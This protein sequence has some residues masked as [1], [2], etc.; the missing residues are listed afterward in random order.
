M[1]SGKPWHGPRNAFLA[2]LA[3]VAVLGTLF[4]VFVIQDLG[5]PMLGRGDLA[6]WTFQGYYL[7]H[8]LTLT[9][10]PHLDL[11]ND[12]LF[13]PYGGNNVFQPWVLEM[14]LFTTIAD[15]ALGSG[16][17]VQLYYL[18]T[19]LVTAL[20]AYVLLAGEHGASRASLAAIAVSF[21]NFYAI[22]KYPEHAGLACCHWM[23]L[24]LLADAILVRRMVMGRPWSARLLALRALL[25][26]LL[27]GQDLGYVAGIALTSSCLCGLYCAILVLARSRFR[28]TRIAVVVKQSLAS[29]GSSAR[30]HRSQVL[31]VAF[32]A[33]VV[34]LL[35]TPL[36]LEISEAARGFDFAH[37]GVGGWWANPARL[38]IPYLPG[39]N[40]GTAI[41]VFNDQMESGHDQSPGL[42]FVLWGLVGLVWGMRSWRAWLPFAVLLGLLV[43]FHPGRL[44]FL[45][46][47]PWFE[48]ARVSGRFTLAY[49]A[50]LSILGLCIP[51]VGWRG[52][53]VLM[54]I[55]ACGLLALETVT[56]CQID[57]LRPRHF[58]RPVGDFTS[59][60]CAVRGE[61]G[62]AVLDWPFCVNS[63]NAAGDWLVGRYSGRQ[64]GISS[65]QQF[66]NKKVMGSHF[67]RLHPDQI[68]SY[69]NAGWDRMF[70][71]DNE[72]SRLAAHQRRDFRP[73][74][75]RFL[76][77]FFIL[78]DFC[79][80]LIYTD[81]LPD[82]TREGFHARFGAPLAVANSTPFGRIEFIP[83]RPEWR[84]QVDLRQG[85][86]LQYGFTPPR[87][88]D[89]LLL[90]DPN[91]S[92]YLVRGWSQCR[93]GRRFSDGSVAEIGF[94]LDHV[95]PLVLRMK[96]TTFERQR[97]RVLLNGALIEERLHG[98]GNYVLWKVALPVENLR[99]SN[100]VRFELPD[101]HS[102][103]S[104]GRN[105]D[106]RVLGISMEWIEFRDQN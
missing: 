53:K 74:Q 29:L 51:S 83:K 71:P 16:P 66:H 91:S 45:R 23:T 31:A 65:L 87:P 27:L 98:G 8:N 46:V 22:N 44:A 57:L 77:R 68:R 26:F 78:N 39:L 21:C 20:A 25:L 13:Y 100:I 75:W 88:I 93:Q 55:G 43:S 4:A 49:P 102:P 18:L 76:E 24:N 36:V 104:V 52:W 11:V 14:H 62:E 17:W 34:G 97:V 59:L 58:F 7:G 50:L 19:V 30:R 42:F 60:M 10:L 12:Q 35:W 79:G 64:S 85:R 72:D 9:P 92:E 48:F 95:Q 6:Q 84:G 41:H 96:A 103:E 89:R 82:V 32:A 81:L 73:E 40:P 54:P 106:T 86:L 61:A 67:G 5:G 105:E 2:H 56:A 99:P 1:F 15:R 3:L 63:G 70:F 101:A 94:T 38:L 69:V 80:I 37:V 33:A 28:P 47:L 90:A